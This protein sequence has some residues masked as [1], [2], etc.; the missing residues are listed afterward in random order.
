M[1]WSC[2]TCA[3]FP[4]L[5]AKKMNVTATRFLK[6]NKICAYSKSWNLSVSLNVSLMMTSF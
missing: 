2:A 3:T 1:H 4:F 5:N 6:T